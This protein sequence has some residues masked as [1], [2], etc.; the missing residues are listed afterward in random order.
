MLVVPEEPTGPEDPRLTE[1]RIVSLLA[2]ARKA[3]VDTRLNEATLDWTLRR[4]ADE[5]AHADNHG[6]FSFL[7]VVSDSS[8]ASMIH[9]LG[10][11]SR[12]EP[13]K[14][15][16]IV[17][18]SPGGG[19]FAGLALYDYIKSLQENGHR[20]VTQTIGK[21]ASMGGILLQA[22]DERVAGANSYMLI[23]EV[24]S[25]SG[26]KTSEMEDDLKF[27]KRLQDRLLGILAA[28]SSLTVVQIRNR[29]VKRDWW[30]DAE[31]MLK[32]GFVDRIQ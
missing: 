25:S 22:G 24:S 6:L 7:G 16:T 12:R 13:G 3:D 8:V 2:A 10:E 26:G 15:I 27:S 18:N 19:V 11:F 30:L 9:Q 4:H 20:V 1:A 31:E 29:W 17:F 32:L 5:L 21:A 28:R 14:D 23:H